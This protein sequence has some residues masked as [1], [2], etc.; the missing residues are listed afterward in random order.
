VVVSQKAQ[1]FLIDNSQAVLIPDEY[2][3]STDE[4]FVKRD[5]STGALTLS[6]KPLHPPLSDIFRELDAAGAHDFDL[7]RDGSEPPIER[8]W[9]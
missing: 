6:E 7:K 4:V 8:E 5:E 1:V 3:F 2:R 9:I